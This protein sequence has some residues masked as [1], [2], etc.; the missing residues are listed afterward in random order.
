MP[1]LSRCSYIDSSIKMSYYDDVITFAA[2]ANRPH[3]DMITYFG[4]LEGKQ[5]PE[6]SLSSDFTS[7]SCSIDLID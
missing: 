3:R 4:K 5:L 1:S 6:V 7:E 2:L